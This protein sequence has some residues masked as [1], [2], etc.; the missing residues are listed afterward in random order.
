MDQKLKYA[1][2][3]LGVIC[4]CFIFLGVGIGILVWYIIESQ[5]PP[6]CEELI[7]PGSFSLNER[8]GNILLEIVELESDKIYGYLRRRSFGNQWV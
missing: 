1:L 6:C 4:G 2:I 7:I 8:L 5:P 3:I